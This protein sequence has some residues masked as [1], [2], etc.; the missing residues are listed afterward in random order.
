MS[1]IEDDV[2][3][4]FNLK[5]YLESL[6]A[7]GQDKICYNDLLYDEKTIDCINAIEDLLKERKKYTIRLTDEEYRRVIDIA[8]KD[9][10][11]QKDKR[12][13]ELEKENEEL[14]EVKISCS[15]VNIIENLQKENESKQKAYDDC[16]CEYKKYK[17]FESIPKQAVIDKIC[18]YSDKIEKYNEYRVQGKE[19]DVEYYENITNTAI[20]QVLQELLEGEK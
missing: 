1:N 11:E 18:K 9:I 3:I 15:A 14:L 6:L 16:Y 7:S 12:I 17:Q 19:T 20:V 13:Q 4:L 2:R 5:C 10:V 8:Q